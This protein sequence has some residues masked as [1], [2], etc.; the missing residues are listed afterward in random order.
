MKPL[1]EVD[2]QGEHGSTEQLVPTVGGVVALQAGIGDG[3][4]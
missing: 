2:P 3:N 4:L 1:L